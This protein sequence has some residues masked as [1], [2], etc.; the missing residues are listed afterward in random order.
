MN[1]EVQENNTAVESKVVNIDFNFRQKDKTTPKRNTVSVPVTIPSLDQLFTKCMESA[2]DASYLLSIVQ[3]AISDHVRQVLYDNP[4]IVTGQFP[5]DQ[6][7]W[8]AMVAVPPSERAIHGI[9]KETWAAFKADYLA[10]MPGILGKELEKVQTAAD[11]LHAKF[12][13]CRTKKKVI[14]KLREYLAIYAEHA[15]NAEQYFEC[16]AFLDKKAEVLLSADE[17]AELDAL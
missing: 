12:E 5:V 11:H 16:V 17:T 14:E 2:K 3:D 6:A 8:E 10:C 4:A 1:T 15:P 13:K 7:T 9:A